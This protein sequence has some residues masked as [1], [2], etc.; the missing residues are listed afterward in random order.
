MFVVAAVVVVVV[1]AVVVVV[2]VV[3]EVGI[4]VVGAKRDGCRPG[5]RIRRRQ[6]PAG[7]M[8]RRLPST[9]GGSCA[10][11]GSGPRGPDGTGRGKRGNGAEESPNS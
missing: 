11:R 5:K 8:W 7:R 10:D 9:P 2:V 1:V 3:V 4:V 6:C